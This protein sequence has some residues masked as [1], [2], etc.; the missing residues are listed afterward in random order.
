MGGKEN[1]FFSPHFFSRF[2]FR[3][4]FRFVFFSPHFSTLL[5]FTY[6]SLSSSKTESKRKKTNPL[7]PPFSKKHSG[8]GDFLGAKQSGWGVASQGLRAARLPDDLE[9]LPRAR[10]AAL[11][12]VE[13][14]PLRE[15]GTVDGDDA[16]ALPLSS[17]VMAAWPRSLARAVEDFEAR[18]TALSAATE[19]ALGSRKAAAAA[20]A[21][22]SSAAPSALVALEEPKKRGRKASPSASS[23]AAKKAPAS[24]GEAGAAA[25]R[26]GR[27]RKSAQQQ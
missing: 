5:S 18:T 7:S 22:S 14:M 13:A 8:P 23:A 24:A 9:L 25:P 16:D 11:A 3:F 12:L 20:P 19:A 2:R 26:R 15:G 6:F 21:P 1:M 17:S 10:E 27:P 4:R